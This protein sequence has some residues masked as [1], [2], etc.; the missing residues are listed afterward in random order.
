MVIKYRTTGPQIERAYDKYVRSPRCPENMQ[1]RGE[2]N[3]ISK[4]SYYALSKNKNP[5]VDDTRASRNVTI[6]G[7]I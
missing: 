3:K 4:V 1:P 5:R 7:I 6:G 2:K